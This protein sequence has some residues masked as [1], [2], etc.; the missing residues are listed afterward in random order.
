MLRGFIQKYQSAQLMDSPSSV[1]SAL[2]GL[3]EKD[4]V[5]SGDEGYSIGDFFFS[6]WMRERY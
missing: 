1:Q 4:I 2:R 3:M 6:E 5:S